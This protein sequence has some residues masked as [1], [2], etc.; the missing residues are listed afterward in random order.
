MSYEV[1]T[2]Y[3]SDLAVTDEQGAPVDTSTQVLTITLP[4]GTTVIPVVT[5]DSIGNYHVDYQLTQEGLYRFYWTTTGPVTSKSEYVNAEVF[6]SIIGMAEAKTFINF[7]SG[8]DEDILRQIMGAATELAESIAGS[9]VQRQLTNIRIPGNSKPALRLPRGPL[10][11]ESAVTSVSSIYGGGPS[12]TYAN[13]DLIVSPESGV[14][15]LASL[16][17]FWMG[18]W[19]ATYTVGRVVIP[20][21]IQLAVKEIIYDM[22]STQRP[23]GANE[24]EPGPEATARFEQMVASYQIPSHAMTLLSKFEIPGFA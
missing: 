21:S 4:D 17:S 12:W 2:L 3:T 5:H 22:W 16:V 23:Y 24:M 14:V 19:K 1:G 7:D 8:S 11:S 20:P 15:Q 10:P 6:R 18:P 13:G 9:C